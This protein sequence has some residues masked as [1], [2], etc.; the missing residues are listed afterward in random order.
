MRAIGRLGRALYDVEG[1]LRFKQRLHPPAGE[2]VWLCYPDGQPA[3]VHVIDALR[4]FAGGD[5][6]GFGVRTVLRH[7]G[8]LAWVLGVPLAPW[9]A[10][11]AA[12][13]ITGHAGLLGFGAGALALW[14]GYDA[15]L[16][17]GLLRASR[18]PTPRLL[19]ALAGA[20]TV[21]AALS[22]GH[23][24]QV[25]TGS[26]VAALLRGL[27]VIA[28]VAASAGRWWARHRARAT[29]AAMTA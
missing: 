22:I 24:A 5:L 3:A 15:L 29:A 7:P 16:A 19:G 2:Q 1:L 4:A 12:I 8:A 10:L 26:G 28:P 9:T 14:V 13:A 18:R 21:D 17:A 27:A 25:G 20:A 23:L 6:A 11:L